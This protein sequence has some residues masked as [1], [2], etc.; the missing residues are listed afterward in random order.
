M[1]PFPLHE[2]IE[3]ARIAALESYAILDTPPAPQFD[4]LAE[5]ACA[6]LAM[7]M[8][9]ICFIDRTRHWT[10][11][12]AGP[13]LTAPP[14]HASLCQATLDDSSGLAWVED[15]TA[16][17]RFRQHPWVDGGARVRCYAGAALIDGDGYRLGTIAALDIRPRPLEPAALAQLG[18]LANEVVGALAIH[19]AG[20]SAMRAPNV[21]AGHWNPTALRSALPKPLSLPVEAGPLGRQ[22]IQGWLG[23]R[24]GPLALPRG[25]EEAGL[26]VLSV[27][28]DSPAERGGVQIG[29]VLLAIDSRPVRRSEDIRATLAHRWQGDSIAL[30]LRR[31]G[32]PVQ[33]HITVEPLPP[34]HAVKRR[35]TDRLR[36]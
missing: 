9:Q 6:A 20:L 21:I 2:V 8:A 29:D 12:Q 35:A 16:Q 18:R 32:R 24:T 31:A 36:R 3:A 33:A 19:R 27:A 28:Q 11:A 4:A 17:P 25:P 26:P 14:R 23:V 10:K 15:A 5:S 7:P 34:A 22:Q 13:H 1:R 30:Q